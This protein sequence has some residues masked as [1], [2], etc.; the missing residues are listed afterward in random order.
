MQ[1]ATSFKNNYNY[2]AKQ[3]GVCEND[4]FFCGHIPMEP[5]RM[6][7]S[8][9]K[10]SPGN[11]T[12]S[13]TEIQSSSAEKSSMTMSMVMTTTTNFNDIQNSL[14]FKSTK[15]LKSRRSFSQKVEYGYCISKQL[16]CD[17]VVHCHNARDELPSLRMNPTDLPGQ[18]LPALLSSNTIIQSYHNEGLELLRTSVTDK[19]QMKVNKTNLSQFLQNNPTA[20]STLTVGCIVLVSFVTIVMA[21]SC[22]QCFYRRKLQA[23]RISNKSTNYWS[24]SMS[25]K[26]AGITFL[27]EKQSKNSSIHAEQNTEEENDL[28]A[29]KVSEKHMIGRSATDGTLSTLAESYPGSNKNEKPQIG[30]LD[31]SQSCGYVQKRTTIS[32][33]LSKNSLQSSSQNHNNNNSNINS[34]TK[35]VHFVVPNLPLQNTKQLQHYYYNTFNPIQSPYLTGVNQQLLEHC[36]VMPFVNQ[37]RNQQ[38]QIN[39]QTNSHHFI[40]YPIVDEA[41]ILI[42]SPPELFQRSLY[43]EVNV[44]HSGMLN[45]EILPHIWRSSSFG[46]EGD[47]VHQA[48]ND[49][50]ANIPYDATEEFSSLQKHTL[51]CH[52]RPISSP[53]LPPPPPPYP[54]E[55]KVMNFHDISKETQYQQSEYENKGNCFVR[56]LSKLPP[57]NTSRKK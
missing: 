29:Q 10:R 40:N 53:P 31:I 18:L 46:V 23:M 15:N 43:S 3:I 35:S 14:K 1:K 13:L 49:F 33:S 39:L 41:Q 25:T 56:S 45:S 12:N 5:Y 9:R 4:E 42:N 48:K 37:Q 27:L 11:I 55:H 50:T 2:L 24:S 28:L 8:R 19:S 17:S 16:K 36:E 57:E 38:I 7:Y 44:P 32:Q 6:A 52:Q 30:N 20:S 21:C 47:L 51:L 26:G 34:T 54:K 22:Y